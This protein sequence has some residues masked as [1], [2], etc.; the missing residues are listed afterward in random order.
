[1][2]DLAARLG[3]ERL[4]TGHYARVVDGPVPLLRM[5]RDTL[6]D[7][8]YALAG[9]DPSSLARLRFPLGDLTKT[10]VREIAAREGLA[11]AHK[12]DSQDLCFL[13]GTDLQRFIERHGELAPAPGSILDA[14]GK[15]LGTHGGAHA[16]TVGQR[17]GLGLP[18]G[19]EP[20]FVLGTDPV[21]NTV[22]VGPR[23]ALVT[24]RVAVCDVT[25]RRPGAQVDG[26]RVRS[27]GRL[28]PCRLVADPGPGRHEG[29]EVQ[30]GE[31]I[32][33]AAPGQI[34]CLYEGD[35]ILGYGTVA[36]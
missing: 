18:G 6:K 34:A 29:I 23:A 7:Q 20:L 26:V 13:A 33:R 24:S 28:H 19:P 9:L 11:V 32:T 22:T 8:S 30:L 25:L 12:P 31:A 5:A 10:E 14:E 17:H 1:M 3:A 27:H 21:A 36:A 2:L 15:S 16:F 4:V 35:V